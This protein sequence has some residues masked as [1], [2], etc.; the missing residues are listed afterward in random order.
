MDLD[1]AKLYKFLDRINELQEGGGSKYPP[2]YVH[3]LLY[4][5]FRVDSEYS[6]YIIKKWE[7]DRNKN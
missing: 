7:E 1:K 3:K 2:Y 4:L 5:N 6:D